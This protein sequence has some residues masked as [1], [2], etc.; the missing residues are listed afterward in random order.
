MDATG[1]IPQ[2]DQLLGPPSTPA[3]PLLHVVLY[4]P[5]IPQNT[6]NIGRTCVALGA[7]LWIVR[8]TGFRIGR[9]APASGLD[10]ITGNIS[11]GKLSITGRRS[12]SNYPCGQ[13]GWSPSSVK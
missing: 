7:K 12:K 1:A 11:I 6:G 8:P 10:W 2:T 3:S 5:E 9:R 4:Q 13:L